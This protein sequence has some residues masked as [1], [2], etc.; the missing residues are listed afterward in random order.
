MAIDAKK[1]IKNIVLNNTILRAIWFHY[2]FVRRNRYWPNFK[3][4][5]TYNEKINYRKRNAKHESFSV[6]SDKVAA[7]KWVE[8]IIGEKY[9]IPNYYVGESITPEIVMEIINQK[10]DCLLKA[11]H[12]SGVVKILTRSSTY[13]EVEAACTEVSK[14]LLLDFG[15][16]VDEPWYSE[17]NPKILVEKRLHPESGDS[18]IK[19]YKFHVFKQRDGVVETFVAIDFDRSSNHTRS[20]FNRNFNYMHLSIH[21]PSVITAVNKPQ[22]YDLMVEIAEKLAEPFSYVRVDL[23]NVN[24]DI[25]F[26]EMTFAPG[27]GYLDDFESYKHDVWMGN[28]WHGDPSY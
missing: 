24:G 6:C 17:I 8:N 16:L 10:G 14:Q 28:K 25:Y 15:K 27:S 21:V 18:D 12:N 1:I 22:N 4:P 2:C 3:S 26:G 13:A 23:Y 5:T 11:N 9:I 20:F 7:K 19:D